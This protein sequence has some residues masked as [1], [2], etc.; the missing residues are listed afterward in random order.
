MHHAFGLNIPQTLP[1]M[2]DPRTMAVLVYDMQI[3]VVNQIKNG[4]EIISKAAEVVS[5]ARAG[6]F[7]V[8]FTRYMSLPKEVAGAAQLR[9]A[10]AWQRV[11]SPEL[12]RSIFLPD[13][14]GFQMVPELAARPTEAVFDRITMSAFEGNP[15]TIA[16]RDC[17]IIS[18]AFV[19]VAL[20][21]GIEPSVRHAAD[22]G[23]IPILVTDACGAGHAE[24][25]ERSVESLKFAGDTI[26]TDV[27]NISV[28]LSRR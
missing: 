23:F 10:M 17:G 2:C 24:A 26:F 7:R 13:S 11:A 16:L 25:A 1:E 22:L 8:F 9:M 27:A 18:V 12:V 5:A 4:P 3:G 6:G 20:E 14:P 21:V 15:L 28:L 19:G